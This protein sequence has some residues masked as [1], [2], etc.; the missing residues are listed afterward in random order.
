MRDSLS[1]GP[2]ENAAVA[3]DERDRTAATDSAGRFRCADVATG[4][5]AIA[6]SAP[7]YETLHAALDVTLE[8]SEETYKLTRADAPPV[9]DTLIIDTASKRF[10]DDP[11]KIVFSAN[12]SSGGITNTALLIDDTG[13]TR[14]LEHRFNPPVY[15]LHDT[16]TFAYSSEDAFHARLEIIDARG[17]TTAQSLRLPVSGSRRPSFALLR[18]SLEGFISG[19]PGYLQIIINDIDG[20]CSHLSIDWGDG[21]DSTTAF[22]LQGTYWHTYPAENSVMPVTVTLF[23]KEGVL[24][25]TLLYLPVKKINPPLLDNKL[26]FKPCQFCAPQDSVIIIGVRILEIRDNYVKQI[27]WTVNENDQPPAL[28]R[29]YV[30]YNSTT[31]AI[32]DSIGN[33]FVH[34]FSTAGFKGTNIVEVRVVDNAGYSSTVS[35]SFYLAGKPD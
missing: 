31:G 24:N 17:D 21:G 25:D 6:I 32:S 10:F 11:V 16:F 26:F 28:A 29:E 23:G 35:G 1:G 27:I 30:E 33:L 8:P 20:I 13:S 18:T 14:R 3:I 9:I 7:G 22:G 5:T 15:A 4:K 19:E 2:I 12:D 34:Q